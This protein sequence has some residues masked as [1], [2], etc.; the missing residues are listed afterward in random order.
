MLLL[1]SHGQATIEKG[2]SINKK[3]EVENMKELSYVSQRLVCDNINSTGDSIYNIKITNIMC[4]Y[5]SN[6]RQKYVKYLEDQKLLSSQNKK[7]RLTSDEIQELKNKK[8]CLE[9]EI[10]ALIRSADEFAEKAEENNDVT[11]ICKSNSV[12]RSA[13]AKEE[14]LLEITNA[15]EDLEKKIG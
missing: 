6:A 7:R 14:N 11:S 4:I 10:K 3:L 2:F 12:G 13:K 15:I 1:L 9:K 5:V 8:R